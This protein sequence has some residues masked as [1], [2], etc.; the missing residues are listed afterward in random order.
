MQKTI[1]MMCVA[2]AIAF[3]SFAQEKTTITKDET[4]VKKTSTVPQAVHN[5]F[6]KKKKHNGVKVTHTKTVEK[7]TN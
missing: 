1:L 5:T 4:K 6:S 3:T 2:T 7:K